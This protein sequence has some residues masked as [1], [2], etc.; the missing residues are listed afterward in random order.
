MNGTK[1]QVNGSSQLH[2]NCQL[3]G[4]SQLNGNSQLNGSSQLKG[5]SPLKGSSQ[6]NGST[7]WVQKRNGF[8]MHEA[9]VNGNGVQVPNGV[10]MNFAVD[11]HLESH[12]P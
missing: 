6:L 10:K 1:N 2:G 11:G 9:S 3:K 4:S 7:K 5:S 12:D 8:E